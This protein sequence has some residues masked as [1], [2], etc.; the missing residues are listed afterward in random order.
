MSGQ[1]KGFSVDGVVISERLNYGDGTR[2]HKATVGSLSTY[3]V[4]LPDGRTKQFADYDKA[5]YYAMRHVTDPP[6]EVAE[7]E[8]PHETSIRDKVR[9]RVEHEGRSYGF[10]TPEGTAC[11]GG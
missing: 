8:H 2:M 5:H 7:A 4:T 10:T 3:V 1:D 11:H 9:E 6:E